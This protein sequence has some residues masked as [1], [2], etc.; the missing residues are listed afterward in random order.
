VAGIEIN[1]DLPVLGQG[2]SRANFLAGPKMAFEDGANRVQTRRTEAMDLDGLAHG[3][4]FNPYS[5]ME[6]LYHIHQIVLRFGGYKA[7]S[8]KM[9]VRNRFFVLFVEFCLV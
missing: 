2:K 1:Q 4:R 8:D 3:A 6:D 5:V 7:V 9:W